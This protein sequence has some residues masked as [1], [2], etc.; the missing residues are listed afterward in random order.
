MYIIA[1]IW[2]YEFDLNTVIKSINI[3]LDDRLSSLEYWHIIDYI[4]MECPV[5]VYI[6]M[7]TVYED[8]KMATL[9]SY[10]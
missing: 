5:P 3:S 1:V 4:V 2:Q 6:V 10:S 7:Y 8:M 9:I